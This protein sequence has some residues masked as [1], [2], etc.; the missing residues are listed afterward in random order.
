MLR[1]YPAVPDP[2]PCQGITGKGRRDVN[3]DVSSPFVASNMADQ[4]HSRGRDIAFDGRVHLDSLGDGWVV[5]EGDILSLEFFF[6]FGLQDGSEG[7]AARVPAAVP[8][9]EHEDLVDFTRADEPALQFGLAEEDI[10]LLSRQDVVGLVEA[11]G[12]EEGFDESFDGG[13]LGGCLLY[14]SPS[15]RDRT[16]SRMPSSA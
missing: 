4:T 16:R 8:A 12:K 1:P 3:D 11:G 15:P 7:A 10:L 9:D 13:G 5:Q 6:E 2:F 14:T